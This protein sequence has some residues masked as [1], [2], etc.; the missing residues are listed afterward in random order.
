MR[1]RRTPDVRIAY[2]N[3][4]IAAKLFGS[5]ME[6]K[7]LSLFGLKSGL[8]V[9]KILPSDIPVVKANELRMDNLFQLEDGS[10]AIVDYE[11]VF[12]TENFL[13]Y[14]R[15]ILH[16]LE[17]YGDSAGRRGKPPKIRMIVVYTADIEQAAAELSCHACTIRIEPAYL[18][19]VDSGKWLK[20]AEGEIK[21][22]RVSDETLMHL[23]FLPLTYKGSEEKQTAIRRCVDLAKEICDRD[24]QTFA[25]AGIITFTDK[26][27]SDEM[28]EEIKEVL[29]MT[30]LEEMI[31]EE[32]EKKGFQKGR[33]EGMKRGRE[34]GIKRGRE[35]GI[36]RGREEGMKRGREEGLQRGMESRRLRLICDLIRAGMEDE[37][38][39]EL[40]GAETTKEELERLRRKMKRERQTHRKS[41][42]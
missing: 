26:V 31:M 42:G 24:L 4:D 29:R 14:G 19:G 39:L 34:E 33:E 5:R 36:K 17:R 30:R 18:V 20:Q 10:L 13:K 40:P 2:Q 11:S 7:A 9:K 21:T 41:D 28:R 15:Y 3:K 16:T 25:L 22:G 32:G 8:K 35:E 38:I 23:V 27:I 12:R 6:G 37:K 1:K